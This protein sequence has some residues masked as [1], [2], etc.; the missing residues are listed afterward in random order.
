[1]YE[2]TEGQALGRPVAPPVSSPVDAAFAALL[3]ELFTGPRVTYAPVLE[4]PTYYGGHRREPR[5]R[6]FV[7]RAGTDLDDPR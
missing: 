4:E 1:M 7:L 6:R 2:S 3:D 5:H